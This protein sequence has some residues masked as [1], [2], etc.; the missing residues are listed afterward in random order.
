M[1][2]STGNPDR[3]FVVHGR[4]QKARDSMFTFLRSLGLRPIEWDQAVEM[5]GEGS[6]YMG[7]ILDVAFDEGQAVVVLMT[8]DD[9][10]YL[11]S[12]YADGDDDPEQ[13]PLG[14]AR[15]N[16]L[17]EAGMAMG[18]NEKRTI[19]VQLG[20]LRPFSDVHGRHT[21]RMDDSAGKRKS[22]AQRLQSAG[23]PV[24][25]TGSDWLSAG[26]FTPPPR[27]G[28][29]LP[30]GRKVPSTERHS[31]NLKGRWRPG[32]GNKLDRIQITNNGGAPLFDIEIEVPEDLTNHIEVHQ[33]HLISKLPPG[34]TFT[35]YAWTTNRTLQGGAPNQFELPVIAKLEDGSDFRQEVFFDTLGG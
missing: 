21:I 33:E 10:A 27:P 13:Q 6:P 12:A 1:A 5:T 30:L 35:V 32:T 29:G 16:V 7:Q 9:I 14:Q 20:D 15:P 4:N 26:D 19:L 23:C 8:P 2:S 18:R 3:V 22:L 11:Q 24:D 34:E 17:F 31:P 28:G 25:M